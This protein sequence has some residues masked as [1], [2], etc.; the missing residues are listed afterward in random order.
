MFSNIF[1]HILNFDIKGFDCTFINLCKT[2]ILIEMYNILIKQTVYTYSNLS[3][4]HLTLYSSLE[5]DVP[6]K[7]FLFKHIVI[8]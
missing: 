7:T 2:T 3:G 1:F 4:V 6:V 5:T 8:T